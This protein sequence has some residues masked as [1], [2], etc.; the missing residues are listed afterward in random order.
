MRKTSGRAIGLLLGGALAASS[1]MAGNSRIE[2][3]QAPPAVI[4]SSGQAST[5]LQPDRVQLTIST[6]ARSDESPLEAY[7]ELISRVQKVQTAL[8]E[9]GVQMEHEVTTDGL[10]LYAHEDYPSRRITYIAEVEMT[11]ERAMD[12]HDSESATRFL[13]QVLSSGSTG[14][15]TLMFVVDPDKRSKA[16]DALIEQAI[17]E[18]RRRAQIVAA[19]E[20]MK[21]GPVLSVSL[22]GRSEVYPIVPK[23]RL[24]AAAETRAERPAIP[25]HAGQGSELSATVLATFS[26]EPAHTK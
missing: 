25:I 13:R 9:S 21:V 24:I 2:T 17:V 14:F 22:M 5:L 1:A 26:L 7:D 8:E 3:V 11:V 23:S 12:P 15:R 16:E 20:G 19:P 10:H 18:A 6:Q 4:E